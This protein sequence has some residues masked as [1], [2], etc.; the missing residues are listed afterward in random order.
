LKVYIGR[1]PSDA[2][3]KRNPDAEQVKRIRIDR[4]D[5]WNMS[6]TLADIIL[7]MLKQL[8]DTK[9]GSPGGMPGFADDS[10]HHWPQMCFDFYKKDDK[11]SYDVGHK[12]W[13]DIMDKMIWSFEQICTEDRD[14]QFH[15]GKHSIIWTKVDVLGNEVDNTYTGETYYRMDKG[16][17]DTH[18]FN[19]EAYTKYYEKIQE[20]L[21]LFGEHYMGLWD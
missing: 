1:Y 21:N 2:V 20:G 10:N 4:W 8:R 16:P 7:P 5:T 14:A 9:H 3:T 6:E 11:S 12:Q 15:T 17:S 19:V 18:S 13:E